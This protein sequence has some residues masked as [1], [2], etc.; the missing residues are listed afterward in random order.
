MTYTI[1][2]RCPRTARLGI[3]VATYSLG[4]GGYCPVVKQGL[5]A[6]SSQAFA[7]PGLR[8]PAVELLERGVSPEAVFDELRRIDEFFDY[9]Q[10]GIVT[11]G[12]HA[13]CHTGDRTRA[14]AGHT[15]GDGFVAMGNVLE[16]K[17]VVEAIAG[18]F[19][20]TKSEELEERLLQAIEAGCA[21]GGQGQLNERSA[22]LIVTR[23]DASGLDIDLRVDAHDAAVPELRR[24]WEAYKPYLPY[25]DLRSARPDKT[26]AQQDW[27]T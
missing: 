22:A 4:V 11:Q 20:S 6:L 5:A 3:G 10:F 8:G 9:R 2:G 16:G 12:G 15:V 25:Y 18:S 1:L 14:W 24:V 7:N 21:A 26:P 23:T 19:E 17:H 13:A 27:K